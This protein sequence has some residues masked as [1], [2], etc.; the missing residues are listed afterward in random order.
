[1]FDITNIFEPKTVS[2]ALGML[3]SNPN[4]K[5]IGGGTDVLIRLH[6]GS[7]EEVEL[8]SLRSIA[9]LD[10]IKLLEDG[11]ISIGAMAAFSKVFRNEI[12]KRY[13]PVLGEAVVTVGGP[14]IRNVATIGGNVCNGAVSAD[15][16]STLLALNAVVKLESK[17]GVRTM[18][19]QEFYEGPGKVKLQSGEIL[20][21]FLI[22]KENYDETV[23]HYIK[24]SNR[25]ALDIAMLGV[26]VVCRI[27]EGKFDDLRIALGVAAPTPIRC[28]EAEGF[29]KG[30][31]A[32][33]E[34]IGE[35]G[36]YALKSS[37]ARDSWRAS[38]AYREHLIE[39]LTQR[40]IKEAIRKAGGD[41]L[42]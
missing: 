21:A 2:E 20:T 22:T 17:A 3:D 38:K 25:K 28:S 39:T 23:G 13:I 27:K 1:M 42:E 33:D 40:A 41:K 29:A 5:I 31:E 24:Y 14:Q 36:Q 11:T 34:I 4:L 8:L 12:I 16:A 19:I 7:M 10:E 37:K 26:S 6:H 18:P 9:G 30:K 15:S 32:T 35:I